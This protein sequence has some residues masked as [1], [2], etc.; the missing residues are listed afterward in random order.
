MGWW[1]LGPEG[2]DDGPPFLRGG[3]GRGGG[4]DGRGGGR[5]GRGG[6][7]GRGRSTR[8]EINPRTGRS[9]SPILPVPSLSD[10]PMDS[11]S[12]AEREGRVEETE[13]IFSTLGRTVNTFL[14]MDDDDQTK[15]TTGSAKYPGKSAAP[16]KAAVNASEAQRRANEM[17][18]A[19]AWLNS[20][21]DPDADPEAPSPGEGGGVGGGT[22]GDNWWE[23]DDED[24]PTL[25][26][27]E[28]SVFSNNTGLLKS[29]EDPPDLLTMLKRQR[30][31]KAK[32][33]ERE[34]L[35]AKKSGSLKETTK[36]AQQKVKK[37]ADAIAWWKDAYDEDDLRR[38]G[39][40][41]IESVDELKK[42]TDWW[43]THK[44]YVPPTDKSFDKN[45]KKAMKVQQV[46]GPTKS[47]I[48]AEKKAR[49][50]REA[51]EWW[52]KQGKQ[53]VEE[54][55]D[56]EFNQGTFKKVNA[57]FGEWE[58]KDL[59]KQKWEKFDPRDDI[60]EA[61][62][63]ANDLQGC[64]GLILGGHFDPNDPHYN[65]AALNRIKDIF[66]D[67][68]FKESNDAS[69]MEEALRWWRLNASSFD[70]LSATEEDDEMFRK[71][72]SLLA[73]FGLKEGDHA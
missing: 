18:S 61:Q 28:I 44:D 24:D 60:D 55:K 58:L 11:P 52:Q 8:R 73:I 42:V 39:D 22:G 54:V 4:R 64:L 48:E 12:R 62:R 71:A 13:S 50:L 3:P 27:D 1:T 32:E 23:Q 45:K 46:L 35:E 2:E 40:I 14:G 37:M 57:L 34:A 16:V 66:V 59:P 63:R 10:I 65:S 68:K 70:P 29:G 33:R 17:A 38:A 56:F 43:S 31:E 41:K 6:P 53:H 19:M 7:E 5:G 15:N 30:E 20:Q 69:D 49:E 36:N 72:K 67:W 26:S 21:D 9:K 25:V 47:E 51:V